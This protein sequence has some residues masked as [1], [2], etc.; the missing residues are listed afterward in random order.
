MMILARKF[1]LNKIGIWGFEDLKHAKSRGKAIL[2]AGKGG[3]LVDKLGNNQEG[4][5]N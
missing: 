3:T 4:G 2:K 5:Y 1:K